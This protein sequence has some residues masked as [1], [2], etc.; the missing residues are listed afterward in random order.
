[1]FNGNIDCLDA[2]DVSEVKN[3]VLSKSEDGSPYIT[4]P[5]LEGD[6]KAGIG[7]YII[8]GVK[9]EFYP[10]K[11]DVFHLTYESAKEAESLTTFVIGAISIAMP[12]PHNL[13]PEDLLNTIIE[14]ATYF[15]D[16]VVSNKATFIELPNHNKVLY[17][18]GLIEKD[19]VLSIKLHGEQQSVPYP[20]YRIS[21][22]PEEFPLVLGGNTFSFI[23]EEVNGTFVPTTNPELL[24]FI[25]N[26]YHKA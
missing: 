15:R 24:K 23:Q 26:D 19:N 14:Q 3:F 21:L 11:P 5:T 17:S 8:R 18:L 16:A 22:T 2:F 4:I 25:T 9:G 12:N 7:D 20:T 10:C 1:M 6:M 13:P